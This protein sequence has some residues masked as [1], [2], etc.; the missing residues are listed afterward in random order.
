MT[1]S[2]KLRASAVIRKKGLH[3]NK[4]IIAVSTNT[5]SID[6]DSDHIPFADLLN[7]KRPCPEIELGAMNDLDIQF[8]PS[9]TS[10]PKAVLWAHANAIWGTQL[11]AQ[12]FRVRDNAICLAFLPLFHTNAQSYSMPSTQWVGVRWYC[13][14]SFRHRAFGKF[15][16][17]ANVIE[18]PNVLLLVKEAD[19]KP[20]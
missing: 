15:R 18:H 5:R 13:C 12:H 10:H 11:N 4:M 17:A 3:S 2:I 19:E 20:G 7:E 16:C 14:P 9:T 8:T 6:S 1:L